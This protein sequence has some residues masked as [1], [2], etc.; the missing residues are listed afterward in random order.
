[1]K[2]KV[3]ISYWDE[4][5]L[6]PF[7]SKNQE[8]SS[9]PIKFEPTS[10]IVRDIYVFSPFPLISAL[11]DIYCIKV[12]CTFIR[13]IWITNPYT[14]AYVYISFAYSFLPPLPSSPSQSHPYT[15]SKS[16]HCTSIPALS[17]TIPTK[18]KITTTNFTW[19]TFSNQFSCT[20]C[21]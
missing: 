15:I 13:C 1:M 14:H 6:S 21:V 11:H 8:L 20:N 7:S 2:G 4:D 16:L 18:R 3:Y 19:E 10:N 17:T 9:S 5:L 12:H